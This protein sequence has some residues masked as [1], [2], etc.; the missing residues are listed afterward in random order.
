MCASARNG[1][2]SVA[3]GGK[4]SDRL[5]AVVLG[6]LCIAFSAAVFLAFTTWLLAPV[7]PPYVQALFPLRMWLYILPA[8]GVVGVVAGVTA[9]VGIQKRTAAS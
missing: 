7:L 4:A 5:P 9:F 2:K 1:R 3:D 8:A 6:L